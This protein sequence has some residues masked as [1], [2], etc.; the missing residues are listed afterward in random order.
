MRRKGWLKAK[1]NHVK[2]CSTQTPLQE[3]LSWLRDAWAHMGGSWEIQNT[4]CESGKSEWSAK[5]NPEEML[6]K[7]NSNYH[8]GTTQG[9]SLRISPCAYPQMLYSFPLNKYF[10]CFTTF[11]LCGYSFLQNWRARALVTDHWS[12]G[13][14][15]VLSLPWLSLSLAG[16]ASHAP[17]H[18]RPRP[19]EI[20]S[21]AAIFLGKLVGSWCQRIVSVSGHPPKF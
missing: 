20:I 21:T 11:C 5:G 12:S 17:S 9:V 10:T 18:C 19:S 4:D 2:E 14:D 1:G 8:E 3:D 15:L 13:Q 7:R 6:H 16:N